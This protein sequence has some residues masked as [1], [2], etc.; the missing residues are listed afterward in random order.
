M[1]TNIITRTV[2][3]FLEPEKRR[4]RGETNRK[5]ACAKPKPIPQFELKKTDNNNLKKARF[6]QFW[7]DLSMSGRLQTWWWSPQC[8]HNR[9]SLYKPPFNYIRAC[10]LQQQQPWP[11]ISRKWGNS[12]IQMNCTKKKQLTTTIIIHARTWSVSKEEA[13]QNIRTLVSNQDVPCGVNLV[14]G[15]Q[16]N[17]PSTKAFIKK[18]GR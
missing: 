5:E 14:G 8:K 9:S 3:L 11:K 1:Q 4:L 7:R 6:S 16:H 12:R 13:Q 15:N 2:E 17:L 18:K 10:A